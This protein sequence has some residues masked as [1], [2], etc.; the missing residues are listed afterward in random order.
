EG[1]GRG[2]LEQLLKLGHGVGG[3]SKPEIRMAE[4]IA[5]LHHCRETTDK[6][7][8][9]LGGFVEPLDAKVEHA[10]REDDPWRPCLPRQ[11]LELGDRFRKS[12]LRLTETTHRK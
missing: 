3:P 1:V 12:A 2:R 5:T 4:E 11:A 10:Q 9:H 6:G 8:N 7:A